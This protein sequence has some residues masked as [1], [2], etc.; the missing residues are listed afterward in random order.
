MF[1]TFSKQQYTKPNHNYNKRLFLFA[2]TNQLLLQ[3]DP[4]LSCSIIFPFC[5]YFYFSI[6]SNFELLK[7]ISYIRINWFRFARFDQLC[8]LSPWR[9]ANLKLGQELLHFPQDFSFSLNKFPFSWTPSS[10]GNSCRTQSSLRF[11]V[12]QIQI[13]WKWTQKRTETSSKRARAL[14]R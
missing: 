14:R 8:S 13:T 4:A 12:G 3:D 7:R 5:S 10:A 11:L 2:P 6:S 1:V 9:N